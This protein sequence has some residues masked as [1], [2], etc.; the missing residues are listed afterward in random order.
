MFPV[1]GGKCFRVKLFTTGLRNSL[2]DVLKSQMM[3]DHVR[4][5][6]RQRSKDFHVAGFDGRVKQWAKCVNVGG[7]YVE[8]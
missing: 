3:P 8:K 4:M 7:G 2:K 1:Y 6:L 5:W